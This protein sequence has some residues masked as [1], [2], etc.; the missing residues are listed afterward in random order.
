MEIDHHDDWMTGYLD[1]P[2]S[3]FISQHS[4]KSSEAIWKWYLNNHLSPSWEHV[5][6][7]LYCSGK[8]EVLEVLRSHYLK[9]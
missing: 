1:I 8:H 6:N 7:A 5:A 4:N 3:V 2:Y 9:G